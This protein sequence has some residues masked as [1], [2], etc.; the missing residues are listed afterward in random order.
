MS[1]AKDLFDQLIYKRTPGNNAL[2]QTAEIY[3]IVFFPQTI[4]IVKS[5]PSNINLLDICRFFF[6][7]FF[8]CYVLLTSSGLT[9]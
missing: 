3:S 2:Y 1:F 7:R 5:R 8:F 6:S 4:N 9:L